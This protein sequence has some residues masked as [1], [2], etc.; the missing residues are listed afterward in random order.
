MS[1]PATLAE[2]LAAARARLQRLEPAAAAIATTR[3]AVLVDIRSSDQR[4]R[5]GVVDGAIWY[6]RNV[7]EWRA[8][9]DAELRDPAFGDAPSLVLMCAEGFQS[10][11]AAA[12][13][14]DL[15]VAGATDVVD[16]FAGWRAAGLPVRPFDEARDLLQGSPGAP[17]R[18]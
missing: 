12:T 18:S 11:L 16:G 3:G 15:G 1:G 13:L 8:A 5:D 9:P 2:H 17:R 6:P 4:R 14:L 7:L 10:S